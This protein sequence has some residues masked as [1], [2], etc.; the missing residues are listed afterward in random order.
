MKHMPR[1]RCMLVLATLWLPAPLAFAHAALVSSEPG[2]RVMLTTPP[3]Q[4]RLCF[5]E[6]VEAKF[7]KV[8]L[9]R[10]DGD[11]GVALGTIGIDPLSAKC[12]LVPIEAA[13]ANGSYTIRYRVLSVDGHVVDYGYGFRLNAP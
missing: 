13:L 8:T 1:F 3:S 6:N 2:R 10:A 9:S 12:L 7:S 5:N 4:I 11:V